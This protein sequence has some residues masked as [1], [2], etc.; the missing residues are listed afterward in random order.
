MPEPVFYPVPPVKWEEV[1]FED[2]TPTRKRV[3][4]ERER[5]L[6]MTDTPYQDIKRHLVIGEVKT[7]GGHSYIQWL[8]RSWRRVPTGDLDMEYFQIPGP[9]VFDD[10]PYSYLQKI[11]RYEKGELPLE[12]L[13]RYERTRQDD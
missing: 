5:I 2:V 7:K 6:V 13:L 1:P 12:D 10:T 8:S 4:L 3:C 11:Y 9:D